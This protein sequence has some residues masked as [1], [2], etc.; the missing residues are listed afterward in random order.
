MANVAANLMAKLSPKWVEQFKK[1]KSHEARVAKVRDYPIQ[2]SEE[3]AVIQLLVDKLDPAKPSVTRASQVRA[4][5]EKEEAK[6]TQ[7][8]HRI[9]D[10]EGEKYWQ[11]KLDMAEKMDEDDRQ[12]DIKRR[13]DEIQKYFP[14][15]LPPKGEELKEKK[16]P[17]LIVSPETKEVVLKT[18]AKDDKSWLHDLDN[19]P[20]FGKDVILNF[21]NSGITCQSQLFNLTYGQALV[22][23]KTPLVLAKIKAKFKPEI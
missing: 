6:G 18:P 15:L 5:M 8:E 16:I 9:D 14:D 21:N 20:G 4:E 12:A 3:E 23:A 22:I 7:S 1:L 19:V 17:E 13:H 11:A 10:P 2:N